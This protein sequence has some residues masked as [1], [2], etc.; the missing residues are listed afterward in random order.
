LRRPTPWRWPIPPRVLATGALLATLLA[1]QPS[2]SSLLEHLESLA[3]H[4]SGL[5]GKLSSLASSLHASVGAESASYGLFRLGSLSGNHYLGILG[6]WIKLPAFAAVLPSSR[7]ARGSAAASAASYMCTSSFEPAEQLVLL[8]VLLH[9]LW[10][11]RPRCM[12]RHAVCSLDAVQRGRVWTLLTANASHAA[13][14][15]L[16]HNCIH[17]LQLGPLLHATLGCSDLLALM[18]TA[19]LASSAASLLW[20]G[21]L[22]GRPKEG[23][24]PA[25]RSSLSSRSAWP[26]PRTSPSR[27]GSLG[28]S[29]VA[30]AM[31]AANAAL[32]PR[33]LVHVY[34][35]EL[36]APHAALLYLVVDVVASSS[37]HGGGGVDASAHAGGAAVGY[38]LARRWQRGLDLFPSF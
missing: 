10:L 34:G 1:T 19:A 35:L 32:Y 30:M 6:T 9:L 7:R 23:G 33:A 4:P 31:V 3:E 29:G 36:P 8:S 27:A 13:F 25:P 15:H 2:H 16:L 26:T 21:V 12:V 37:G 17:L 20:N 24:P 5:L 18:L 38:A 14:P 22:G 11:T 28:A